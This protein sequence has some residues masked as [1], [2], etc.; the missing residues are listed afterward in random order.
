VDF[1]AKD[2]SGQN[3]IGFLQFDLLGE[4]SRNS[5]EKVNELLDYATHFN[6]KFSRAFLSEILGLVIKQGTDRKLVFRLRE[7]IRVSAD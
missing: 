2:L 3:I 5:N 7:L 6:L 4:L 1:R